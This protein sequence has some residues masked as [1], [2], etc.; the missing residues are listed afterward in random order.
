MRLAY[1]APAA[2]ASIYEM[3]VSVFENEKEVL[4][5]VELPGYRREEIGLEV[6]ESTL[7]IS[8]PAKDK[9]REGYS[10]KYRERGSRDLE[11]RFKLGGDLEASA[12]Q[13]RLENGILQVSV[14][15]SE[16]AKTRRVEIA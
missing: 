3:P 6:K 11:R 5:E 7:R 15:R 13:A 4:L 12:I 10:L 8:A 2:A 14:P 1:H 9:V 16:E